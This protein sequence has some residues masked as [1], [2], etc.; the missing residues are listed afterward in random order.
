MNARGQRTLARK[1]RHDEAEVVQEGPKEEEIE[2]SD[3]EEEE[4]LEKRDAIPLR[5]P[6]ARARDGPSAAAIP[7]PIDPGMWSSMVTVEPPHLS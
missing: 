2:E 4:I 1:N 3:T 5:V 6:G 7:A